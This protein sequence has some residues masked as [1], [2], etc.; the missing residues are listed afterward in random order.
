MNACLI[1][2][3]NNVLLAVFNAEAEIQ[4]EIHYNFIDMR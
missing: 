4:R 1:S 2:I 3:G